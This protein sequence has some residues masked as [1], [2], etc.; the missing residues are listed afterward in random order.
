MNK[1]F[2]IASLAAATVIA[3]VVAL[4]T[5]STEVKASTP[6]GTNSDSLPAQKY[7][8]ACS[9]KAWRGGADPPDRA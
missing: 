8:P 5:P 7:G 3:A 6:A 1:T 4:A 2:V 9:Q